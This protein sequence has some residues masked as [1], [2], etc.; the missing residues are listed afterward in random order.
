L[1]PTAFIGSQLLNDAINA[2]SL[3]L[4]AEAIFAVSDCA[5]LGDTLIVNASAAIEQMP[6]I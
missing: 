1:W 5:K 2:A 6:A 4:M 3:A